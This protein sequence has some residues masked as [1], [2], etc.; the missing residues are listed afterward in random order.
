MHPRQASLIDKAASL[1]RK[2]YQALPFG[3]R[4]AD[5]LYRLAFD[6]Q[7]DF[8][9]SI[10]SYF[11]T[12][13]VTGLPDIKGQPALSYPIDL[14]RNKL[15]PPGYGKQFGH[16]MWRRMLRKYKNPELVEDAFNTVVVKLWSN[17]NLMKEGKSLRSAE[18]YV[19]T[20]LN[21]WFIDYFRTQKRH[22]EESIF[23]E[24][25]EG[26]DL[27][28][29]M[30]DQDT[31]HKL[32]DIISPSEWNRTLREMDRKVH[33]DASLWVKLMID[34]YNSKEVVGDPV[35]GKPGM[36]PYLNDHPMTYSNWKARIEPKLKALFEDA[37]RA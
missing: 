11:I 32:D 13:D 30:L 25:D 4:L 2:A 3:V 10:Y 8:G 15:A 21:N 7:A 29:Q 28:F 24:G 33:P 35:H 17:P 26:E 36:L 14:R 9:R 18:G 37:I 6:P 12:R 22:R 20:M 19:F 34:G 16:E 27:E 5:L 1:A 31:L 23:G